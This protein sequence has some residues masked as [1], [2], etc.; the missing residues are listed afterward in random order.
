MNLRAPTREANLLLQLHPTSNLFIPIF[1]SATHA[2]IQAQAA[3]LLA[4]TAPSHD[5]QGATSGQ[6]TTESGD[7]GLWAGVHPACV[8]ANAHGGA[9]VCVSHRHQAHPTTTFC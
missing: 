4:L 9:G 6:R 1:F 2:S 5:Q 7:E 3:E 8:R